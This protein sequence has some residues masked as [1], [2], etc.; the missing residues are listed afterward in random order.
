[1]AAHIAHQISVN[2]HPKDEM[3]ELGRKVFIY[4]PIYEGRDSSMTYRIVDAQF[5]DIMAEVEWW[6]YA[7]EIKPSLSDHG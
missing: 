2:L 7:D 1:M 3:P 5:L 4:A 6:A